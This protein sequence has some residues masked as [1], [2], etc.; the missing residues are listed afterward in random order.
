MFFKKGVLINFAKF[1]EF[2]EIFINTFLT[3]QLRAIASV[4]KLETETKIVQNEIG[5]TYTTRH[6][7]HLSQKGYGNLLEI[8]FLFK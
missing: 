8:A 7:S 6:E 5:K 3:E 1:C 2:C 4:K